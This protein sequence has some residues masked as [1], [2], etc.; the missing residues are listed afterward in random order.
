M[1]NTGLTDVC[2]FSQ[3]ESWLSADLT[4]LIITAVPKIQ[5]SSQKWIQEREQLPGCHSGICLPFKGT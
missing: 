4:P 2:R 1:L 5:I 3:A